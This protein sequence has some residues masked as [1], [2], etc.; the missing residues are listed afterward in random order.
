MKGEWVEVSPGVQRFIKER[1][2]QPEVARSE[3]PRPYVVSD[4]P[5]Y[6][7]P[8][9]DGYIEGRAA[10]REHFKR[11]NTREVD[12]S[13]WGARSNQFKS[14]YAEKKAVADEWKRGD[15]I[16]RDKA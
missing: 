11:T 10:R 15:T 4:I 8:L 3:L 6:K 7:S 1:E 2:E 13:E 9:G 16:K 12:P 5:A 14:S